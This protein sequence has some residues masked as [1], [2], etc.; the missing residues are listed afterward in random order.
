MCWPGERPH[1]TSKRTDWPVASTAAQC[2]KR[3]ALATAK[4]STRPKRRLRV[5]NPPHCYSDFAYHVAV[6]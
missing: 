3:T 5:W 6:F 2:Q 1:Y 4:S